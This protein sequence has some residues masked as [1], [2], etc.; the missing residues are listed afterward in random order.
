MSPELLQLQF[1]DLTSA[2]GLMKPGQL[3]PTTQTQGNQII[4]I[5]STMSY[6]HY[7]DFNFFL[8]LK[9]LESSK[10]DEEPAQENKM[11]KI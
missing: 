3:I 8:A 5:F 10:R 7:L 11:L 9:A 1:C 4:T 2:L 6:K